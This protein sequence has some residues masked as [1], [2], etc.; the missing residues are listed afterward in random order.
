MNRSD[1]H[2]KDLLPSENVVNRIM[3]YSKSLDSFKTKT[4]TFVL[5]GN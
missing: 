1:N 2:S 5:V 3:N 4:K